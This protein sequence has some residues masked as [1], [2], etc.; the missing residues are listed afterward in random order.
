MMPRMKLRATPRVHW[1]SSSQRM[2]DSYRGPILRV[3]LADGREVD[4]YEDDPTVDVP[5][6]AMRFKQLAAA[7]LALRTYDQSGTGN[8]LVAAPGHEPV[9]PAQRRPATR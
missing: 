9:L 3:R 6:G 4:V 5:P 7:S 2:V 8:D 1:Y